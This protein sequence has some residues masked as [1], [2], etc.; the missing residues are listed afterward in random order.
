MVAAVRS[1]Y[2]GCL[3]TSAAAIIILTKP[4]VGCHKYHEL[5]PNKVVTRCLHPMFDTLGAAQQQDCVPLLCISRV[6][7]KGGVFASYL[8]HHHLA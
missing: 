2:A 7:F 8:A 6:Y 4:P 5:A 1:P 3:L